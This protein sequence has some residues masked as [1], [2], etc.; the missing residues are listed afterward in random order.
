MN[1][2]SK[3][4]NFN[5]LTYITENTK[6]I[7]ELAKKKPLSPEIFEFCKLAFANSNDAEEF[8]MNNV[9]PH[10]QEQ[11]CLTDFRFKQRETLS[12]IR[13]AKE[14]ADKEREIAERIAAR[15]A[16][17]ATLPR[18][19][20]FDN[21]GK[22]RL[23]EIT[24]M[25]EFLEVYQL[26]YFNGN[27][28]G[29]DG[30]TLNISV[31]Q[32]VQDL[33][34]Q[35]FTEKIAYMTKRVVE[36]LQN[37]CYC[38]DIQP[39]IDKIHVKNG[40]ITTDEKGEFTVFVPKK[41]FCL[42][43]LNVEYTDEKRTPVKF[44]KYLN[45]VFK[46]DDIKTVKQYLGYLLIPTNRLQLCMIV[47]GAGGEGKSQLGEIMAD[48]LGDGN[49]LKERLQKVEERFGLANCA[50]RLLYLDDDLD[51]K[52]LT[53]TGNFKVLVTSKGKQEAEM[54]GIQQNS[55]QFYVRFLCFSNHVLRSLHDHTE[56][57]YRRLLILQAKSRAKERKD[58]RD[59]A[60]KL[61]KEEKEAIFLWILEGLNSLIASG[62]ELYISAESKMI[63]ET[64]K[65]ESDS[66]ETFFT[67]NADLK[68]GE[69]GEIHTVDLYREYCYF[70]G[71]NA[72]K[73][74]SVH[75]FSRVVS[76]RMERYKIKKV[77]QLMIN[78]KRA[79]GFRGITLTHTHTNS[80]Y[81]C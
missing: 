60:E 77:A 28:Y 21:R 64:L 73:S 15:E 57:F 43:R 65:R 9:R 27:F 78:G 53:E 47:N 70:C 26:K 59:L 3:N 5:R 76:E 20:Y 33:L 74:V 79:K 50:N 13:K 31:S 16:L 19:V 41:E 62:W 17:E 10:A 37:R 52:A 25:D 51:G 58:I 1:N 56:G 38:K 7:T 44:L 45:D 81:D 35:H 66:I 24:F 61:L 4:E 68:L 36:G 72:M 2:S 32:A 69:G 22:K 11:K 49:V 14:Q 29:I 55:A 30:Y 46:H 8:L 71:D 40:Y 63:S 6:Y 67:Q 39:D 18:W 42:N 12:Y 23:D 54:K 48:I 34:G 75:I 80:V